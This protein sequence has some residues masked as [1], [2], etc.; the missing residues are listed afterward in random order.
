MFLGHFAV[1]LAAKKPAPHVSLGTLFLAAQFLDL[2]WPMFLLLGIE[3][4]KIVPGDTVFTPLDLHDYPISHSLLTVLGWSA[5]FAGLYYAV[6]RSARG[7]LVLG[8]AVFSHWLLDFITHRPDI[9]LFPGSTTYVGAGLW[10]SF[11][12]TMIVEGLLFIAAVAIYSRITRPT[13]KTGNYAFWVLIV[14]LVA[15]YFSNAFGPPP[16]DENALSFV[17]LMQWLFV[18]WMYWIDR[19]RETVSVNVPA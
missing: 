7:A 1:G 16:P 12:G 14:F 18:P 8:V 13:D 9:P 6:K 11:A 17:A 10:N 4:V 2:I 15:I 5:L 3:S 19:H